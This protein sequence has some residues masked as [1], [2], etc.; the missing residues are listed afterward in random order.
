[1]LPFFLRSSQ[2][3]LVIASIESVN[4]IGMCMCHGSNDHQLLRAL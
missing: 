1:V 4:T 3:A 2:A